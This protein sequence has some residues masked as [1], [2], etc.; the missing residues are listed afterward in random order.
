MNY[1]E[2]KEK[3]NKIKEST[4]D[5]QSSINKVQGE[6]VNKI[7]DLNSIGKTIKRDINQ[8][9]VVSYSTTDVTSIN[10]SI[11][12]ALS[13]S[14]NALSTLSH[15]ATEEIKRIVDN[16]NNSIEYDEDGK[17]KS[18]R[19][20]YETISLS[21]IAGISDGSSSKSGG[22][23]YYGDTPKTNPTS[24]SD[25]IARLG[26]EDIN[27]SEIENWN[28]YVSDFLN[29]YSLSEYVESISINGKTITC[30]LKNGQTITIEN[31]TNIDDLVSKIKSY[32]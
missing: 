15:D 8:E 5:F 18:P 10:S 9:T 7:S 26:T 19:L 28:L 1:S 32:L 12:E 23:G 3:I 27:S 25:A 29:T 14:A 4:Q 20:S 11:N 13:L 31:V 21:S 22:G 17:P 6:L 2:A 24:F 16:Y 30:K